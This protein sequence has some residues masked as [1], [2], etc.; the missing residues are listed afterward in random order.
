MLIWSFADF[1]PLTAPSVNNLTCKG[2]VLQGWVDSIKRTV[3]EIAGER[4]SGNGLN[5]CTE[6]CC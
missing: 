5:Y 6:Y 4:T 1:Q 2:Q 3:L